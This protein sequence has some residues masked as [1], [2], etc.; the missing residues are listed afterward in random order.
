MAVN[1]PVRNNGISVSAGGSVQYDPAAAE[2][3][4]TEDVAVIKLRRRQDELQKSLMEEEYKAVMDQ[5]IGDK[6][7][8]RY[9]D[10]LGE[11]FEGGYLDQSEFE[12][13]MNMAAE[14]KTHGNL[15]RALDGGL[16]PL[17]QYT[18]AERAEL[19]KPSKPLFRLSRVTPGTA[20]A[21]IAVVIM[22]AIL[23]VG[24]LV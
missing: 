23:A 2:R 8:E 9:I 14:A 5:R 3:A 20:L 7:R 11:L 6:D 12:T 19:T 10:Y 22:L 18:R 16:P 17:P 13:R 24:V 4:V 21:L 15:Q 1:A